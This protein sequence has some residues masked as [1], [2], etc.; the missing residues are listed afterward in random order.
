M[1]LNSIYAFKWQQDETPTT[2]SPCILSSDNIIYDQALWVL[3]MIIVYHLRI[4]R[5]SSGSIFIIFRYLFPS[6][7]NDLDIV[8]SYIG[9][10]LQVVTIQKFLVLGFDTEIG[11]LCA[12]KDIF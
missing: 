9:I 2:F 12:F 10:T 1:I 7:A 4:R 3:L 11:R 5:G 8:I 6:L